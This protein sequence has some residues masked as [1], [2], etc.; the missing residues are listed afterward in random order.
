MIGHR[1]GRWPNGRGLVVLG[2]ALALL[3][4]ACGGMAQRS[5]SSEVMD[6]RRQQID[7]LWAH[8]GQLERGEAVPSIRGG[9]SDICAGTPEPAASAPVMRPEPD[10]NP[11]PAEPILD[12]ACFARE[13][14]REQRCVDVCQ[15]AGSICDSATSICRLA[16]ELGNDEW[17]QGRCRAATESCTRADQRCCECS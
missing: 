13:Q 15:L 11:A 4:C 10:E 8:I 14:V 2:G 16:G 6:S 9:Q 1:G 5:K 12:D 17:A 3:L 7:Q